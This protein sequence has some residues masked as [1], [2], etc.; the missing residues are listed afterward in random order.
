MPL[1]LL[2]INV[3]IYSCF[4]LYGFGKTIISY[5]IFLHNIQ[6]HNVIKNQKPIISCNNIV[7]LLIIGMSVL[8]LNYAH[9]MFNVEH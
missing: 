5:K 8:W 6:S 2:V 9:V 7:S 1:G 3:C 4:C